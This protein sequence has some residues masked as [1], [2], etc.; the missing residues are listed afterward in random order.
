MLV[1][2][3]T[4]LDHHDVQRLASLHEPEPVRAHIVIPTG[5]DQSRLDQIVDDIA[6]TD[7]D[8]LDEDV[9]PERSAADETISAQGA[10]VASVNALSAAGVDAAGSLV[11]KSPVNRVAELAV[12][13]NVDEIV[14]ITEPHL[15]TDVLRR[16]W[17]TRLRHKVKLPVLHFIAGTDQIVS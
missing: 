9:D 12:T 10:L 4:A 17:A 7:L 3:E 5:S 2:T 15:V 13:E 6:A 14:V 11:P 1:L 8:E 16:D